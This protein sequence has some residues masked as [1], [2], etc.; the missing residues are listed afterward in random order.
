VDLRLDLCVL[1][2]DLCNEPVNVSDLGIERGAFWP[3][4]KL[5]CATRRGL[6]LSLSL[7][8]GLPLALSLDPFSR[9]LLSINLCSLRLA[10]S[11]S[12][13]STPLSS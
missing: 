11:L 12:L 4:R 5:L 6:A 7:P 9:P 2:G 10:L 3:L 13:C 8:L 1:R